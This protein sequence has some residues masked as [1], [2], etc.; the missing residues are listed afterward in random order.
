MK[1][2]L[3]LMTTICVLAFNATAQTGNDGGAR[4]EE[5]EKIIIAY[6][7]KKLDLTVDEA[8]QFWPVY[9]NFKTDLRT[10]VKDLGGD[11]IKKN[12]AVVGV[13]K[14]YKPQFQKVL[15]TEVRANNVFVIHSEIGRKISEIRDRRQK[16][17]RANGPRRPVA[18]GGARPTQ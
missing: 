9:N 1:K 10:A 2:I 5:V 18:G 7:T 11:E 8:Q 15:K 3:F 14:K 6:I 4:K 12:E 16:N 17:P 13:Q